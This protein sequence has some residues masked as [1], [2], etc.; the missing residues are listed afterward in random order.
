M[1]LKRT[2]TPL[3]PFIIAYHPPRNSQRT[4]SVRV[5]FLWWEVTFRF[6]FGGRGFSSL[7]CMLSAHACISVQWVMYC[8]CKYVHLPLPISSLPIKEHDPLSSTLYFNNM[9]YHVTSRCFVAYY[10]TGLNTDWR[11]GD[12]EQRSLW[13]T[14]IVS[15]CHCEQLSLQLSLWVTVIV[16]NC[17]CEQLSLWAT[18]IVNNCLCEQLSLWVTVTVNNSHCE[19]LSFW[20]TVSVSDCH[21]EQLSLW[22]TVSVSDC[23][24]ERLSLWVT[25]IVNNCLWEQLSLWVTVIVNNCFCEKLSLGETVSVSNCH[26]EQLCLR[27]TVFESNCFC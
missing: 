6:T 24:C 17:H 8:I 1:K 27:A 10:D 19:Q 15:S 26:C 25:V 22:A 16:S 11:K 12:C 7:S 14:V 3:K 4:F 21:C 2:A 5:Y 20:A 13:A 18:V 9:I 23:L